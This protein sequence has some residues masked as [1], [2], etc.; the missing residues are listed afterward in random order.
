MIAEIFGPGGKQLCDLLDFVLPEL[1]G[2]SIDWGAPEY[3]QLLR[4][5]GREAHRQYWLELLGRAYIASS[6]TIVRTSVWVEGVQSAYQ[7]KNYLAFTASLRGLVESAADSMYALEP[8]PM[9]LAQA[10]EHIKMALSD[11]NITEVVLNREL[12]EKLIHFTYAKKAGRKEEVPAGHRAL[13]TREYIDTLKRFAPRLEALYT[14]LCESVHP[15]SNSVAWMLD[16]TPGVPW[17]IGFVGKDKSTTAISTIA[18]SY[19]AELVELLMAGV[20]YALVTLKVLRHFGVSDF[21]LD[22]MDRVNLSTLPIWRKIE[23]H[24]K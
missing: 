22:F 3:T 5:D 21:H 13:Q 24:L 12:E 17:R 10:S 8:A 15:A 7:S 6:A 14:E 20:N 11:A 2:I 1:R 18:E 19:R 9:T 4:K 23:L 16:Q